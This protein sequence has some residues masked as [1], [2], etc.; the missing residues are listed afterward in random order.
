MPMI[1]VNVLDEVAQPVNNELRSD[2][3]KA[4]LEHQ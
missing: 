4:Q 1:M 3:E 2:V